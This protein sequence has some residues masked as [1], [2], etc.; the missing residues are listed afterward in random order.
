MDDGEER[1]EGVISGIPVVSDGVRVEGILTAKYDVD[2]D[3]LHDVH[4]MYSQ[5][6]FIFACRHALDRK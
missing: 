3:A 5:F 6:I 4:K 1:G 2:K